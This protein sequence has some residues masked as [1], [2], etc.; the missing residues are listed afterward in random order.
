MVKGF[1]VGAVTVDVSNA[2]SE[3]AVAWVSA[4]D[5]SPGQTALVSGGPAWALAGRSNA[6]R[7]TAEAWWA[8]T[9]GANFSVTATPSQGGKSLQLT[10]ITYKGSAGIGTVKVASA[11]SGAQAVTLTPQ[12]TGSMAAAVGMDFDNSINRTVGPG[13]T[14]DAQNTDAAGDTYWVQHAIGITTAGT[15]VTLNDT[16]PTQDRWDMVGLEV[17]PGTVAPPP[18]PPVNAP[19]IDPSTPSVVPVTNNVGSV[20]SSAFSPPTAT[21]LYAVFSM[22]SLPGSGMTVASIANSGTP[23]PWHL[24]GRENHTD[25]VSIGGF[26]EVWWAANPSLQSSISVTAT[27]SQPTKNVTPPV[28]ALQILVMTHAAPNQAAAANAASW[29]VDTTSTSPSATLSTTVGNSLVFAVFDNWDTNDTP[30]PGSGQVVRSLV[31]NAGDQDGYW[32]Q[33]RS[34]PTL[35]PGPVTMNATLAT[36]VHWHEIAWEVISAG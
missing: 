22:D 32:L 14:L 23:L 16:A 6:Q 12:A 30:A 25:G 18:P 7:G 1:G 36:S 10:V 9:A 24:L 3:V 29:L 13:Q 35:S 34:A 26:V 17:T 11:S 19:S 33:V 2:A 27:F 20:T 8:M 21:V 5:S 15:A 28:G 4:D 31:L